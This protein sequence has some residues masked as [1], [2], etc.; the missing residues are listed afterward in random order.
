M[1][2]SRSLS[3]ATRRDFLQSRQVDL[4][5]DLEDEDIAGGG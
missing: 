5:N 1:A 4:K 2:R 3:P